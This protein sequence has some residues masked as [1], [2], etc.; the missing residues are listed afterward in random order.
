MQKQATFFAVGCSIRKWPCL[1]A[2][3]TAAGPLDLDNLGAVSRQQFRAIR[4]GD[5]VRQI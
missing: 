2:W 5:V 3:V 4:T 1:A